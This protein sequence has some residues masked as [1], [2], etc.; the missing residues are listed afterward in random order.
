VAA[1]GD[2]IGIMAF[3]SRS[4]TAPAIDDWSRERS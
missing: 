2:G 3:R 4:I 1:I